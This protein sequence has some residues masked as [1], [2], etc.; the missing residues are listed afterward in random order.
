MRLAALLHLQKR[1]REG[2]ELHARVSF[3]LVA[4]KCRIY[5]HSLLVFKVCSTLDKNDFIECVR[6]VVVKGSDLKTRLLS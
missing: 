2:P 3:L 5:W 1:L 6:C 4:Q